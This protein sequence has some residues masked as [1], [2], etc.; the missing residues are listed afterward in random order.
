MRGRREKIRLEKPSGAAA[1]KPVGDGRILYKCNR[2]LP[3]ILKR[4]KP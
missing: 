4:I 2:K 3:K 1:E